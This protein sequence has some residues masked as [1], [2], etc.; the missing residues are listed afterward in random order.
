MWERQFFLAFGDIESQSAG[1]DVVGLALLIQA[2]WR[3]LL[4]CLLARRCTPGKGNE[5]YYGVFLENF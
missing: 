3:C 2:F 4:L 5:E 1:K